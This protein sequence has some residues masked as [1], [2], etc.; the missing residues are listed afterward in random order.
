MHVMTYKSRQSRIFI[1]RVYT[2]AIVI[3][4]LLFTW[5]SL[6]SDGFYSKEINVIGIYP[7]DN[8]Y[9]ENLFVSAH[10]I[11]HYVYFTKLTQA[12]RDEWEQ[13]YIDSNE[14]SD[15]YARTNAAE[16]F[17]EDFAYTFEHYIEFNFI[18]NSHQIF[19]RKYQDY[20]YK[21]ID[22]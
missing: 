22:E 7:K 13:L 9:M 21:E 4:M 11:G 14:F 2:S 5:N 3:I 8:T 6:R 12:Q 10:E 19:F 16:S 17:A 15:S 20:I 18:P 1:S